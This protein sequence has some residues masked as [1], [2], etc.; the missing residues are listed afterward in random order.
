MANEE[1]YKGL[2]L[3]ARTGTTDEETQG[4]VT[5]ARG[6]GITNTGT[7]GAEAIVY[8]A[9]KAGRIASASS[10]VKGATDIGSIGIAG[11]NT[12]PSIPTEE[13]LESDDRAA[14]QSD[15]FGEN[16][17][18]PRPMGHKV[19]NYVPELGGG[20]GGTSD[21]ETAAED[22]WSDT[23]SPRPDDKVSD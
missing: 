19:A 13:E 20:I 21:S 4:P 15:D 23:P 8:G 16:A 22:A 14:R 5:S 1:G 6:L 10:A 12:I 9:A 7:T 17:D 2:G 3:G 18:Q 11:T